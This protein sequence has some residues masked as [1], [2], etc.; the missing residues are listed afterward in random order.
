MSKSIRA[1]LQLASEKDIMDI[2]RH[3]SRKLSSKPDSFIKANLLGYYVLVNTWLLLIKQWSEY[4]WVF[5][6]N[7]LKANGV[8]ELIRNFQDAS[9]QLIA[10]LPMDFSLARQIWNDVLSRRPLDGIPQDDEL[11]VYSNPTSAMLLILRYGKRFS[12]L[13]A[14]LLK[15]SALDGFVEEQRRLKGV[16]RYQEPSRFVVDDVRE[17]ISSLLDWDKLVKQ[18]REVDISDIV[19]TPGVS[20]STKADLVSKLKVVAAERVEYFPQPFGIPMVSHPLDAASVE[21]W[22]KHQQYEVHCVRLSPV[23]KNYKTARVIAPE[24][25]VRQALAR[26]Y[27]E[28]CDAVLPDSIKLHDQ[29]QNQRMA[30]WGSIGGQ[31]ATLDLHAASDS[32]TPSVLWTLLPR[33]FMEIMSR[34]L[35]THYM[36][37]G[38]RYRLES[39]ATMGNSMTF[40]LESVVFAGVSLAATR[41]YCRWAKEE[42]DT[43]SVYGDDIIVPCEAAQTVIEWLE[44]FGFVVNEDKSFF[45]RDLLYRE[46]CGVEYLNG[47]NVSSRY[48]PRFPLI[49]EFGKFSDRFV[50]DSFSETVVTTLSS[51]I[52]LQHKMFALCV[53]ASLLVSEVVKEAEPR[54]TSSTPDQ[55]INDL[56]SYE[57]QYRE[58][59]APAARIVSGK[60]EKM[61]V[62]GMVRRAHLLPV[63]VYPKRKGDVVPYEE[64]LAT[65]YRYQRFL[66]F[67][68]R[69]ETPLDRLLGV[70]APPQTFEEMSSIGD[71]K[72]VWV[73]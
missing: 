71:V 5:V 66:K 47:H 49:G 1:A 57:E 19:F 43:I 23:P 45:S 26:R 32:I 53:P 54:M 34:I 33:D 18:L 50:R 35:P 39:A 46:S 44:E 58:V 72:W 28:I 24:D 12:P 13:E 9:A 69:Y 48:F 37:D 67:G 51:L 61:V 30:R 15:K 17:A 63:T 22:G 4:G 31:Y 36:L 62:P 65:L 42:D 2:E 27:F 73:K 3:D 41:Y 70:T 60:L 21:W 16:Q 7:Y 6:L 10:G 29:S 38:K 52:D 8:I 59:P 56:W 14:D 64:T 55:G 40:W 25:V 20:F 11:S 68:P